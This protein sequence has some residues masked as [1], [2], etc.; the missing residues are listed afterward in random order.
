MK[1]FF[2][3]SGCGKFFA[4]LSKEEGEK[5]SEARGKVRGFWMGWPLGYFLFRHSACISRRLLLVYRP[6]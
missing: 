5:F 2:E 4:A 3:V 6:I 1:L